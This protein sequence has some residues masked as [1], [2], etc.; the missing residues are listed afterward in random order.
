MLTVCAGFPMHKLKELLG[1]I[2]DSRFKVLEQ[3]FNNSEAVIII[4][5]IIFY[6]QNSKYKSD[7]LII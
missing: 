6:S 2:K 1:F 7:V 3:G 4:I 5:I